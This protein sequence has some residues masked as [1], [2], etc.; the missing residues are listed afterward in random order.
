MKSRLIVELRSILH[1]IPRGEFRQIEQ[2]FM[3]V[4]RSISHYNIL[5]YRD[6]SMIQTKY[7]N[8]RVGD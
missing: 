8:N 5:N 1:Y 4:H 3:F 6:K 7:G 2:F